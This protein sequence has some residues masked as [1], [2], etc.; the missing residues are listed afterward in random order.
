ML[1]SYFLASYVVLFH[2]Y[3]ETLLLLLKVRIISSE[4]LSVYHVN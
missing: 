2:C 3:S 1:C 4:E